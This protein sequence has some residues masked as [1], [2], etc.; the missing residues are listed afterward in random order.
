MLDTFARCFVDGEENSAK[1]VGQS[2][3]AARE[4]QAEF[5]AAVLLVH[6][7]K[8]PRN[9]RDRPDER[10][11]SALR[12]AADAMASLWKDADHIIRTVA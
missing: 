11:S 9:K 4:I 3:E 1:D 12:G 7:A 6:H 2:I 8:R 10:G 5:G